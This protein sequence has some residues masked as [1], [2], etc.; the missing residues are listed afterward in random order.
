MES[1]SLSPRAPILT[2][3]SRYQTYVAHRPALLPL[4]DQFDMFRPIRRSFEAATRIGFL[5]YLIRISTSEEEIVAT[6][7]TI[8]G[9]VASKVMEIRQSYQRDVM[10]LEDVVSMRDVDM[11]TGAPVAAVVYELN[12]NKLLRKVIEP[13]TG[14]Y[15]PIMY[16]FISED[17]MCLMYTPELTYLDKYD[18]ITGKA[19]ETLVSPL[20]IESYRPSLYQSRTRKSTYVQ[21]DIQ[22]TDSFEVSDDGEETKTTSGNL[23]KATKSLFV[24]LLRR[25]INKEKNKEVEFGR[26]TVGNAEKTSS[27]DI[28]QKI[29]EK[30]VGERASVGGGLF[31]SLRASTPVKEPAPDTDSAVQPKMTAEEEK[32]ET[33]KVGFSLF[34]MVKTADKP[35]KEESGKIKQ[36]PFEY[37]DEKEDVVEISVG[38]KPVKT[39]AAPP[40]SIPPPK[41]SIF[42]EIKPTPSSQPSESVQSKPK[43]QTGKTG[44]GG[45]KSSDSI[46]VSSAGAGKGAG[47][48]EPKKTVAQMIYDDDSEEEVE[49]RVTERPLSP[50]KEIVEIK[51][52]KKPFQQSAPPDYSSPQHY[53]EVYE[54][55]KDFTQVAS[56]I[57]GNINLLNEDDELSSDSD[58]SDESTPPA[59]PKRTETKLKITPAEDSGSAEDEDDDDSGSG[60]QSSDEESP[61]EQKTK[62]KPTRKGDSDDEDF[63]PTVKVPSK[64]RDDCQCVVQ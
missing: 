24:P 52:V 23:M 4:P 62:G 33:P 60:Q 28:R 49:V 16:L 54:E 56:R 1:Q 31:G 43:E 11:L 25:T 42:G 39:Q 10:H 50:P 14:E 2:L 22:L 21:T 61:K 37:K 7:R 55:H 58:E 18:P 47:K 19:K 48:E 45:G 8:P 26:K 6:A 40:Q 51:D 34:S 27:V 3:L 46:G 5:E 29:M 41:P 44:I 53:N 63:K 35:K 13:E 38:P 15:W 59:Q 9:K 20:L 30:I 32:K 36:A 12:G 17:F 57:K 64:P